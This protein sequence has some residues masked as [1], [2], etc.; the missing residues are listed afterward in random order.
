MLHRQV[1]ILDHQVFLLI[2]FTD[3][4]RVAARVC[5]NVTVLFISKE[6]I[7]GCSALMESEVFSGCKVLAGTRKMHHLEVEGPSQVSHSRFKGASV[8]KHHKFK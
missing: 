4:A 5:P 2:T 7:Q 1:F 6:E 8:V 3:F